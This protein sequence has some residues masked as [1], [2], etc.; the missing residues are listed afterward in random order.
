M[1]SN[2]HCALGALF[3]GLI[4]ISPNAF[5]SDLEDPATLGAKP[6]ITVGVLDDVNVP[7]NFF[8]FDEARSDLEALL[9]LQTT[10]KSQGSRGT[11][12]IFSATAAL[13]SLMKIR[14]ERDYDLSENYL[15]FL[16][17]A[18]M[19]SY[20]SEGS[21]TPLNFPA[22]QRYG[23]IEEASWP[24]ETQDWTKLDE[25]SVDEKARALATC[26]HLTVRAQRDI[27]LLSHL[28][29]NRDVYYTMAKSFRAAHRLDR[30]GYRT[31]SQAS[32]I[33]W[34][35][36]ENRPLVLS[37]EFFYGAWNHRKMVEYG[38]GERD[39]KLWDNG[40]VTTPTSKD[41]SLSREHP[42]GH[43]IVVVGYDDAKRVYYFKNSWGTTGF[44]VTSNLM[45]STEPT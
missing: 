2:K 31:L 6:E 14:E 29:P 18:K 17:M 22:F 16:V 43:S 41:V 39:M 27:C 25:L 37:V 28:D 20:P 11:C 30:V 13:E 44:G 34:V 36:R 21:D 15:E 23:T 7:G 32:D 19:K 1:S 38:I 35:L 5:A 12:S 40:V 3:F 24:Y 9:S 8:T 42:A 4:Q 45:G 10:V 33:R 26:G